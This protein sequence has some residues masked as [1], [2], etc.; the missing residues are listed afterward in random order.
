MAA[1]VMGTKTKSRCRQRTVDERVS[2]LRALLG[3]LRHAAR[4]CAADT[5]AGVPPPFAGYL[6]GDIAALRRTLA[7]YVDH[8]TEV[9]ARGRLALVGYY[10][11][12]GPAQRQAALARAAEELT[13]RP[14]TVRQLQNH[15][16]AALVALAAVLPDAP[17]G[18]RTPPPSA[19]WPG[20]AELRVLSTN[21]RYREHLLTTIVAVRAAL[22]PGQ[23]S[24]SDRG[25]LSVAEAL[26]QLE[27]DIAR[28]DTAIGS[29]D[30]Q[31][32][33]WRRWRLRQLA[34][35]TVVAHDP[36]LASPALG[37]ASPG[38]DT[39]PFAPAQSGDPADLVCPA[40]PVGAELGRLLAAPKPDPDELERLL[41]L[42]LLAM[43]RRGAAHLC[44]RDPAPWVRTTL[45]VLADQLAVSPAA[46]QERLR[47]RLLGLRTTLSGQVGLASIVTDFRELH[48]SRHTPPDV[49]ATAA[50]E[51]AVAAGTHG[52]HDA[53]I[54]VLRRHRQVINQAAEEHRG[55]F[56]RWFAL[57]LAS[58]LAARATCTRSW[59]DLYAGQR[60]VD[61]V[62][63]SAT[64]FGVP[65]QLDL[66]RVN[67]QVV[68]AHATLLAVQGRR[69][70]GLLADRAG[71]LLTAP[72]PIPV[73][74]DQS[75][76]VQP[77]LRWQLVRLEQTLLV[78]DEVAFR[79]A[80]SVAEQLW[81]FR[82]TVPMFGLALQARL[83]RGTR[84]FGLP[85]PALVPPE[86]STGWDQHFRPPPGT[87]PVPRS[88]QRDE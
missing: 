15:L 12:T 53:A 86:P 64:G 71:G 63:A 73:P 7:W 38:G 17:V 81:T 14:I 52:Q 25:R 44:V 55:F 35:A 51:V 57:W 3:Y 10:G 1:A 13:G 29:G 34:W 5:S 6:H 76:R 67:A 88:Y 27:G 4:S 21:P 8:L 36:R 11:L 43:T 74:Q 31:M 82:P 79:D 46:V 65:D 39:T 28:D 37:S 49:R 54:S 50:L 78:R 80:A 77:N 87:L 83:D 85:A 40:G 70:A 69:G 75:T 18:A 22:P 45:A 30:E 2:S 20:L 26:H 58:S 72:L 56:L 59:D 61:E 60:T 68:L 42:L 16:H 47:P 41:D 24:A 33:S 32:P 48:R 19:G 9:D 84:V 62:S 66:A 23:D